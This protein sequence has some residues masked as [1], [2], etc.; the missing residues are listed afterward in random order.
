MDI[1]NQPSVLT[2]EDKEYYIT[3][4]QINDSAESGTRY[5]IEAVEKDPSPPVQLLDPSKPFRVKGL[6]GT[7]KANYCSLDLSLEELNI[8][9]LEEK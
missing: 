6:D 3:D 5:Q 1:Y 4:L 2:I 8:T 7:F 9:A